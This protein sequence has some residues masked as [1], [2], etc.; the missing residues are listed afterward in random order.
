MKTLWLGRTIA[1]LMFIMSFALS[2]GAAT[3]TWTGFSLNGDGNWNVGANWSPVGVP[4]AG[5]TLIFPANALKLSNT[6]NL[7]PD[8]AFGNITLS[9]AYEIYGNR[10]T[11]AGLVTANHPAGTCS[12]M[13]ALRMGANTTISCV[14]NLA[15]VLELGGQINLNG[16]SLTIATASP[17]MFGL[18]VNSDLNLNGGQL[19]LNAGLNCGIEVAGAISGTGSVTKLGP[20]I[21]VFG[22]Y[23]DGELV[24]DTPNTY[25]GTTFVQEGDL[26]LKRR[27]C[28]P[29]ITGG[30]SCRPVTAI[31][32]DLVIGTA[33][34]RAQVTVAISD[35]I[36]ASSSVSIVTPNGESKRSSLDVWL[37]DQAIGSLTLTRGEV[38]VYRQNFTTFGT[39]TLEGNVR[40]NAATGTD[41]VSALRGDGAISMGSG[42][43]RIFD[44]A[45][46]ATLEAYG[47]SGTVSTS[48]IKSNAGA[49]TFIPTDPV[50]ASPFVLDNEYLG[51]T[52]I[53]GGMVN[54]RA[55][56]GFGYPTQGTVVRAAVLNLERLTNSSGQWPEGPKEPLELRGPAPVLRCLI[57]TNAEW[58]GPVIFTDPGTRIE[59]SA[60]SRLTLR[61]ALSGPGG[62]TVIGGALSLAPESANT[63]AGT[64]RVDQAT[65]E[66]RS[67]SNHL[68]IS[69]PLLI[70]NNVGS[71]GNAR[72]VFGPNTIGTDQI[73]D[74]VVVTVNT[75][76]FFALNGQV[77]TIGGLAGAG[78]VDFGAGGRLTVAGDNQTNIFT[79][80]LTGQGFLRK[81]G[82]SRLLLNGTNPFTG[83]LQVVQGVLAHNGASSNA[84]AFVARNA[85]LTGNGILNS[86]LT[87]RGGIVSPSVS[88]TNPFTVLTSTRLD[89]SVLD[90]QLFGGNRRSHQLR[91]LGGVLLGNS[92]LVVTAP[93][94]ITP[95]N[96]QR[97]LIL[98]KT[99]AGP[100]TGTFAGLPES[101][102][103]FAAGFIFQITYAGGDGNDVVITRRA[104]SLLTGIELVGEDYM[105]IRGQ[106]T[107][108]GT[109]IL[110]ATPH[111]LPPIPWTPVFTNVSDPIGIYE[112]I[113]LEPF[114]NTNDQPRHP[115]RFYRVRVR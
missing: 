50:F 69:G 110:D 32:R 77:E 82:T 23:D 80:R 61:G 70:G 37:A 8:T 104:G 35:Q 46:G 53:L 115:A 10:I 18:Y 109:Y 66:L 5:D 113:D 100:V 15:A 48:L 51:P 31:P 28:L 60:L 84:S 62:F 75:N 114:Y 78:E 93:F 11:I 47:I 101:A 74:D 38:W 94:G 91:A 26:M 112:L 27:D 29:I 57:P 44:V 72:V 92:T 58:H 105:H 55:V 9:G 65:L 71:A 54:I 67:P 59:L 36:A 3:K 30:S 21:A 1:R 97:Y 49:I 73:A 12:L 96:G 52:D 42:A 45:A 4:V 81:A 111:L 19:F 39:L 99:S 33:L 2:A 103:F 25:N 43:G 79:G 7:A 106:G 16:R 68:A 20:G 90:I 24:Y 56:S 83:G 76:G 64:C 102:H 89:E 107:N 95:T 6:N 14:G 87:E 88:G 63:F 40:V 17:L 41:G 108:V 86:L 98:D 22:E 85:T 13:L 34:T